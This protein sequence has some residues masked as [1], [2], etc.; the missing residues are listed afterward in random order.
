MDLEFIK[1]SVPVLT[2][3]AIVTIELTVLTLIF[4]T[5]IGIIGALFKTSKYKVLNLIASFYTWIIRG[6][7]M[8]LQIFIIYFGLPSIGIEM[9]AMTAGVLALSINCGAYMTEII[10][11]G[12]QSVDKGQ[13]EASKTLG[14]SYGQT[15]MHVIIPQTIRIILPSVGN[16]FITINKDT[17]IVSTITLVEL[18]RS[19]QVIASSSFRAMETYLLAGVFYLAMTTVLTLLFSLIEKKVS[20]Y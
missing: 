19:S 16:E 17:S 20:V 4:G 1:M 15:M 6:T 5:I 7:P 12:I 2:Q 10:R 14:L 3:G 9:E 8:L 11:G 18:M 13:F